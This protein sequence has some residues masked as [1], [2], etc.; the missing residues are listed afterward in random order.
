VILD[1]MLPDLDGFEICR[2]VKSITNGRA[3]PVIMLTRSTTTNPARKG[4]NAAPAIISP[5]LSIRT[6]SWK[7]WRDWEASSKSDLKIDDPRNRIDM[8][9]TSAAVVAGG[10][11][12]RSN[13]VASQVQLHA[14]YRGVVPEIASRAISKISCRWSARR[15]RR[16]ICTVSARLMRCGR[17]SSRVDRL[18]PGRRYRRQDPRMA[19]A[20]RSSA[21]TTFMPTSTASRS[22]LISRLPCPRSDW[23][24]AVATP[25]STA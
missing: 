1:V 20:S 7:H 18:A 3:V 24:A 22:R 9:R 5:S 13:V 4:S 16:R 11:D 8:R 19:Q 10:F 23:F 21:S 14:K 25:R 6:T 2:R 15:S 17:V 12:V